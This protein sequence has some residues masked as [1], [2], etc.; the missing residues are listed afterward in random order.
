MH[1]ETLKESPTPWKKQATKKKT[2]TLM[3]TATQ[4][5]SG[6][7]LADVAEKT[8]GLHNIPVRKVRVELKP[9]TPSP[10]TVE[11]I[12]TQLNNLG[13]NCAHTDV[14]RLEQYRRDVEAAIP[15]GSLQSYGIQAPKTSKD[16]EIT[17]GGLFR[18]RDARYIGLENVADGEWTPSGS[19]LGYLSELSTVIFPSHFRMLKDN[20]PT[21]TGAQTSERVSQERKTTVEAVKE[22]FIQVGYE[23][24]AALVD[25]LDRASLNAILSNAIA[26]LNEGNVKD[27]ENSDSR[28]VYLVKNYDPVTQEAEAIGVLGIDWSLKI[29]DYK[30]KK[31]NPEHDTTLRITTRAVMY[32]DIPTLMGDVQFV[33]NHLRDSIFSFIPPRGK[34]EIFHTLPHP[35]E[36]TFYSGLPVLSKNEFAEVLILYAPNLESIGSID[37]STSKAT[38]EYSKTVTSGFTFEMSQKIGVGAEFEAGIVLAKGKVTMNLELSFTEQWNEST[39]ETS[40]FSVEAGEKCFMYQGY[41]LTRK[42]RYYPETNTYDYVN[43]EGRFLTDILKTSEEPIIGTVTQVT[44]TR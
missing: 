36:K 30:E 9:Q 13:L 2:E 4:K 39:S 25:G 28:V 41:L 40:A 42:L 33:R 38:T 5:T 35:N 16:G 24:S 32:T 10:L 1:F 44:Q 3:K 14:H 31:K 37:N 8:N 20:R 12:K 34:L 23:A 19:G 6:D 29:V 43:M 26:P 22:M 18:N 27:Y 7:S 21:F 11:T 15:A 17:Y